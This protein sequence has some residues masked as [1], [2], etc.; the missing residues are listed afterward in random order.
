[1]DTG[2]AVVIALSGSLVLWYAGGHVYNR[3]RG[4]RLFRWLEAGLDVLGGEVTSGWMGSPATGARVNIQHAD[5]PFR[6]LQIV[7]LLASREVPLWWLLDHL[8]GRRDRLIMKMTLRTPRR[9]EVEIGPAG[10]SAR[11]WD[12][13]WTQEHAPYGLAVAYHGPGAQEQAQALGPWLATYGQHLRRFSWRK[14]DPHVQLH[15]DAIGLLSTPSGQFLTDLRAA[16][17]GAV[18]VRQ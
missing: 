15:I 18:R 14:N 4:Q 16:L 7:L 12:G 10:R 11:Q 13:S 8:R 3:R 9:G 5:A 1:M 2:T 17:T 6:R